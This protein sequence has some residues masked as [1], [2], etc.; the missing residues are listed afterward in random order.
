MT[1]WTPV[2]LRPAAGTQGW[3]GR[4]PL[5]EGVYHFAVRA[6]GG[7]WRVPPGVPVVDDGFGGEVGVLVV[8][9]ARDERGGSP[10]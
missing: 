10:R 1:G 4:F 7:E 5:A 8:E 2:T 6:D 3:E 9:P